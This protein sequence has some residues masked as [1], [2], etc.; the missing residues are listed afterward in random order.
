MIRTERL[1]IRELTVADAVDY[2]READD[3]RIAAGLR[4]G[5]PSPYTV[6]LARG[7][8]SSADERH[9]LYSLGITRD[10]ALIG[11]VG[12]LPGDDVGRFT[13]E[14]GYW[15]GVNHWGQGYA[16]EALAAFTDYV[17]A[18]TEFVRLEGGV[19]AGNDTSGRV[20]EKCGYR[21]EAVQR[22]SAFKEGQI[23]DVALYV[24][25]RA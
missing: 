12:L 3:P 19:F 6:A 13:A 2:A 18:N 22:D 17:F 14:V 23:L 15:L 24:R 16:T 21:L 1:V 25:L 11:A 9:P 7:F 5:F 8:L 20:L 10:G 4:D